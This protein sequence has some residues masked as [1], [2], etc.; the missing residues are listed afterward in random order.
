MMVVGILVATV[1][2]LA[3]GVGLGSIPVVNEH[4]HWNV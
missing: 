2:A 1:V 4:L 3:C